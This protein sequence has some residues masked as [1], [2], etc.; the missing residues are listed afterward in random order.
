LSGFSLPE[1]HSKGLSC[2]FPGKP[3]RVIALNIIGSALFSSLD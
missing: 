1:D 3:F 2:H